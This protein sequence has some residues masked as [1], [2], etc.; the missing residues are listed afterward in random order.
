MILLTG[1]LAFHEGYFSTKTSLP[2]LPRKMGALLQPGH[3]KVSGS[4]SFLRA[5]FVKDRRDLADESPSL[6]E[7]IVSDETLP[8]I[9][10]LFAL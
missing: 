1:P 8:P 10:G 4:V 7:R 6:S 2:W 3:C 9:V 5:L